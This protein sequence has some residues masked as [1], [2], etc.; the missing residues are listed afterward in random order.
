MSHDPPVSPS[1]GPTSRKEDGRVDRPG[2]TD[3]AG[4]EGD[5]SREAGDE[6]G[7]DVRGMAAAVI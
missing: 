7:D 2:G 3:A 5:A 4:G 1:E 6:R